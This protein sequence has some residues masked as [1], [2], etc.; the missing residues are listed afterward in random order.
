MLEL[1]VHGSKEGEVVIIHDATLERT[2]NGRGQVRNRT[3]SSL[4]KLDAGYWFVKGERSNYPFRGRNIEIPTLEEFLTTFSE[5][6]A[7]IE[8]KQAQPSIV[9]KVIGTIGR[10]G[11]DDRVLLA[12]ENDD[13]M[14]EIRRELHKDGM[15]VATGFSYGEVAAFMNWLASGKQSAYVPPGQALQIPCEHAGM[16][17]VTEHTLQRARELGLEMFVWTINDLEEMSRLIR[18]DVDGI[19]TDYPDRLRSLLFKNTL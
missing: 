6:R 11:K 13:I 7:I 19:I 1:D 10:L 16:K 9:K 18:L 5:A 14:T 12:T 17:L 3:L 8:I 4:K 2:T 15:T